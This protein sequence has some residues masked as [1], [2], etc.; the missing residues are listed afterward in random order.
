MIISCL[1]V[2]CGGLLRE[3]CRWPRRASEWS[4]L[5]YRVRRRALSL[6]VATRGGS[7]GSYG[8]QAGRHFKPAGIQLLE[9]RHLRRLEKIL[10]VA[11]LL[12]A[13]DRSA[14]PSRRSRTPS[15][16]PS[17]IPS[18]TPSRSHSSFT[19]GFKRRN[20][21]RPITS[22]E[23]AACL[24]AAAAAR[25]ALLRGHPCGHLSEADAR[26]LA[27]PRHRLAAAVPGRPAMSNS[28]SK[29]C[30]PGLNMRGPWPGR[31]M[32]QGLEWSDAA[33]SGLGQTPERHRCPSG[34]TTRRGLSSRPLRAA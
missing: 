24:R 14:L 21:C 28:G 34:A 12:C 30:N 1:L 27:K 20:R 16:I 13:R 9:C 23:A 11:P 4:R 26:H 3:L 29:A 25:G 33:C 32:V 19:G 22:T 17:L 2:R 5:R 31:G 18:R 6:K 8:Y 7:P 15:L 10:R